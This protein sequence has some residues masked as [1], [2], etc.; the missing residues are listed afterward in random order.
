MD[1]KQPSKRFAYT[2]DHE[3][4]ILEHMWAKWVPQA[5]NYEEYDKG[6]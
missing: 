4:H 2:R 5:R 1:L 3:G 6:S